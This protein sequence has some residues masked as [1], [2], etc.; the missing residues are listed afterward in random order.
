[1]KQIR[2][3]ADIGHA[4][5]TARH[6]AGLRQDDLAGI[7]GVGPRFLIELEGGKPTVRLDKLLAVLTT[8]GLDLHI[9]G[10]PE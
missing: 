4:V 6:A 9:D 7:A 3:V 8:L 10:M 1:M 2:S 5:R